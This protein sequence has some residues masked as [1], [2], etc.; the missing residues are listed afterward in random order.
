MKKS[1][2]R[3][4]PQKEVTQS[5]LLELDPQWFLEIACCISTTFVKSGMPAWGCVYIY[6][7]CIWLYMVIKVVWSNLESEHDDVQMMSSLHIHKFEW[8]MRNISC[9]NLFRSRLRATDPIQIVG[10]SLMAWVPDTAC[11]ANPTL[12]IVVALYCMRAESELFFQKSA[13]SKKWSYDNI[14]LN[15]HI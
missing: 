7:T 5:H 10:M 6:N 13:M 11:Q 8:F 4:A 14:S 3:V 12:A 1:P 2:T 15:T 9:M